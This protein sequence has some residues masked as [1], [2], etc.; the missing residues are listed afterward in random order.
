MSPKKP[1]TAPAVKTSALQIGEVFVGAQRLIALA[2]HVPGEVGDRTVTLHPNTVNRVPAEAWAALL[3][4]ENSTLQ[5]YLREDIRLVWE[6]S[7]SE[8]RRILETGAPVVSPLE[9]AGLNKHVPEDPID[10]LARQGITLS[11]TE[12]AAAKAA[13]QNMLPPEA[14]RAALG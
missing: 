10:A 14:M 11:E 5:L 13:A 9:G 6:Y 7:P 12:R 4:K 1:N 3:K 2:Y 8:A